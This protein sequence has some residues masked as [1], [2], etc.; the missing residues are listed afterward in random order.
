M[1]GETIGLNPREVAVVLLVRA[2]FNRGQIADVLK[3]GRQSA[4]DIVGWLCD[5]FDCS[6]AELYGAVM[7]RLEPSENSVE[8]K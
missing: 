7:L 8:T 3:I 4:R 2:R 1:T 6:T 5:H